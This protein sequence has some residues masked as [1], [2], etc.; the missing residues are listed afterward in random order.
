MCQIANIGNIAVKV[1]IL[2]T[3]A[4]EYMRNSKHLTYGYKSAYIV[5]PESGIHVKQ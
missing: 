4:R 3:P 1:H 2:F 5:F